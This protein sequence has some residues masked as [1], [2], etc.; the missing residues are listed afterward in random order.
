M[1]GALFVFFLILL[2]VLAWTVES[3]EIRALWNYIAAWSLVLLG[4]I[5]GIA[6]RI[7][8]GYLAARSRPR[9]EP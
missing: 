8:F 6:V 1:I 2:T 7:F 5:T 4:L 9:I 3:P